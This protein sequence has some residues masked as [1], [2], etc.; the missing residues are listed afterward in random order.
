MSRLLDK[1]VTKGED[2][3]GFVCPVT[4]GTCGTLRA[5]P[6]NGSPFVSTGWPTKAIARARLDEHVAEHKGEGDMS[7]LEEFR[8]KHGLTG[9]A[10]GKRAVVT[11][12]DL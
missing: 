1:A 10:D 12:K 8:G 4:D 3:Y 2:G 11:A 5:D 7:T 9:T 6:E